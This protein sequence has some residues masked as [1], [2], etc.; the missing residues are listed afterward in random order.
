MKYSF[1]KY[2]VPKA[3][4]AIRPIKDP[5]QIELHNP[6]DLA[7]QNDEQVKELV[8]RAKRAYEIEGTIRNAV[9]RFS[10]TQN[11][12]ILKGPDQIVKYLENRLNE[13]SLKS[14]EDWQTLVSRCWHEFWKTG[15]GVILKYRGDAK[16]AIR[17]VYSNTPHPI[18][19]LFLADITEFTPLIREIGDKKIPVWSLD[20]KSDD[21]TLIAPDPIVL[22]RRNALLRDDVLEDKND[23]LPGRDFVHFAYKQPPKSSY[24]IG[25]TMTALDNVLI[26][27]R[28]EQS[29]VMMI[30]KSINP[31]IHHKVL[32]PF[33]GGSNSLQTAIDKAAWDH[34]NRP[35]DAVYVTGPGH[36]IEV[37]GQESQALRVG[38]YLKHTVLRVVS[39]LC[40]SPFELGF[41]KGGV[42]DAEGAQALRY[43]KVLAARSDFSRKLEKFILWEI[44]HEGGYDPYKDKEQRVELV[45]IETDQTMVSKKQNHYADLWQKN[46]ITLDEFRTVVPEF[47]PEVDESRL[48]ANMIDIMMLEKEG[49][50]QIKAAKAKPATGGTSKP[51]SSNS[52]Q[53]VNIKYRDITYI[54][55]LIPEKQDH[56]KERL[57][58]L[59][60]HFEVDLMG[61]KPQLESFYTEFFPDD[62]DARKEAILELIKSELQ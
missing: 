44:L 48:F 59:S 25:V 12:F 14:G 27:R 50:I 29:V 9:D 4:A 40:A 52:N 47:S 33:F 43:S 46:A 56:I 57:S 5:S 7:S 11:G 36:E 37:H 20:K 28:L 16:R 34:K 2:V 30:R 42:N 38:E 17:P 19:A 49:E 39:S 3:E 61:L 6:W 10:D 24:G 53:S 22:S 54:R 21:F 18:S 31:L 58:M 15:N 51:R 41:E 1:A 45:F 55:N 32:G 62:E 60:D 35:A 26:L 8:K 13:M 23:L